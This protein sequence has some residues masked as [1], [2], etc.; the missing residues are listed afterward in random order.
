M[1]CIR[2]LRTAS[3]EFGCGQCMPCRVNT[4]R[5]WVGR[6]LLEQQAHSESLFVTL[7]YQGLRSQ[8]HG[9]PERRHWE[10]M[11][12][13]LQGFLKR[14]RHVAPVRY[15][16]VG[17]Y[18]EK[19]G[20][21]HF[22]LAMFGV[23]AWA[24]QSIH[25]AWGHGFI[26][27][28]DLTKDSAQYLC[29]Y[30]CKKMTKE[31]D[32]RLAGRNPEKAWMSRNPGIGAL[33]VPVLRQALAPDGDVTLM[34]DRGD[35]PECMRSGGKLLPLGRYVRGKLRESMGWSP[36]QP[37]AVKKVLAEKYRSQTPDEVVRREKRRVGQYNSSRARFKIQQGKKVL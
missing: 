9:P 28:G 36:L 29:G 20:R 32:V 31:D 19:F 7:T 33:A 4:R 2:P 27:V 15:F 24:E 1:L 22:H 3:G 5:T 6:L 14:F 30:V 13:D 10:L 37:E 25:K 8:D 34:V 26:H 17:E 12:E 11:R 35:V 23:G 18:G 21:P 16:A